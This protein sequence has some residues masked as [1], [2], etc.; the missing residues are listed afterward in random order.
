MLTKT[1]RLIALIIRLIRQKWELKKVLSHK[2]EIYIGGPTS[3]TKNT[4]LS[5]NPN[6]NGMRIIGFG[7]VKIG[8][9]FHSGTNCQI[10]TS[11]H[12]YDTGDALPYDNTY[13]T[14]DVLIENNVWLGNNVIILGGVTL[15]EGSIVQAGSVVVNDVAKF[16]IVGGNPAKIF[17]YR[18]VDHYQNLIKKNCNK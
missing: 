13:I 2:N 10:I 17:K 11:Y 12:N 1:Y 6:F 3:L 15:G 4:I 18:D 16:A 7:K 8:D 9:N 14:K 5:K